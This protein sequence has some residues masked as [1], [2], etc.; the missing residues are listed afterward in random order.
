MLEV[1]AGAMGVFAAALFTLMSAS[2]AAAR[3]EPAT[4]RIKVGRAHSSGREKN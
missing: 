1:A 4:L 3:R 2:L